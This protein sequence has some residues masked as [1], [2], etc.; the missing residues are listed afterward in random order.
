MNIF[1]L[2][3]AGVS[4]ESGVPTFRD[5]DGLWERHRIE[6]VATPGG[7]QRDPALVR[8]FYD[9][10]RHALAGVVPNAAHRALARLEAELPRR[11]GTLFLCTQNIDDLHE[12]G[13]S[14][15]VL[16]MH[17]ELLKARCTGCGAVSPWA[18]DIGAADPC[19]ACGRTGALRPHVV[20]FGEVPLEMDRIGMALERADLFAAI[21]TSGTV[22]PASAFARM[23]RAAGV[24]TVEINR[25][26]SADAAFDERRLGPASE[27]VP[28]WVDEVLEREGIC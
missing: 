21:G 14:R 13:G 4:A 20:W 15:A 23:A 1:V 7:F 17:G 11:G 10:R 12:R 19:P 26:A 5:A 25:E 28:R 8:R 22:A 16:H 27:T 24:P 3:G 18:G 2:T 6:E 9:E